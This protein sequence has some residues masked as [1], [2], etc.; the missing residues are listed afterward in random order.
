MTR[1][2]RKE[3]ITFHKGVLKALQESQQYHMEQLSKL[4]DEDWKDHVQ[5]FQEKY[6]D[7]P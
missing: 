6:N 4:L 1:K 3:K 5:A 7:N 2:E